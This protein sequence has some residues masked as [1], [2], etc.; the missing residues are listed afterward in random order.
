VGESFLRHILVSS[1][2]LLR[3]WFR[4]HEAAMRYWPV[5]CVPRGR[6]CPESAVSSRL[7]LFR[8]FRVVVL[9]AE[10]R[11]LAFRSRSLRPEV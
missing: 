11:H 2:M 7:V 3:E 9:C 1:A 6:A 10:A 5:T 8:A 4:C